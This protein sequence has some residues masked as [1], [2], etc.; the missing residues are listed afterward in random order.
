M[1]S[2]NLPLRMNFFSI[3]YGAYTK[4]ILV[5]V[6]ICFV[7]FTFELFIERTVQR[8]IHEEKPV[9]RSCSSSLFVNKGKVKHF[10]TMS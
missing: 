1:D 4:F 8:T 5:K 6:A 3:L 10:L 7:R 9:S 2:V